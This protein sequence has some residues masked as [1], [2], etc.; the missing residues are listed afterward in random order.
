[1]QDNILSLFDISKKFG[2]Q[3]V[4]N[5]I[6]LDIKKGE[7]LTLLGSSG[8]G[9]TTLLRLIAGLEVLDYGKIILH[10]KDISN[11]EPNNRH[12][13]TVFQN[14]A[15]FPHL[16]V[17]DNIAYGLRIKGMKKADI[18]PRI[19]EMLTLVKMEGYEK[20]MP[21]QLSGGQRQRIAIARAL[22]NKPDILLLDEPLGA[23]DLKLRQH[24]QTELK[25]IQKKTNITFIYVTHDQDEALNLSDRIA[26]LHKGFIEQIGTPEEIY[27]YPKTRYVAEFVGDR[28]ILQGIVT[29]VNGD[30]AYVNIGGDS[31]FCKSDGL[32]KGDRII[33]AVHTD[34]MLMCSRNQ[35]IGEFCVHGEVFDIFYT[36]SQKKISVK[37]KNGN[38]YNVI[39]YTTNDTTQVG[40]DV[41]ISWNAEY[42]IVIKE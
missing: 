29:E 36:G 34:K 1:M 30:T 42:G 28:N 2:I 22:I 4:L 26:V 37:S 19:N 27:L 7:F 12:V 32:K 35:P 10:G 16:N 17:F 6:S 25:Q 13:N 8:C 39:L 20:R 23:L 24:M 14:Y 31:A 11:D 21:N 5:G 40:Q 33:I 9:K 38:I 18:K 3:N 41:C 15:L